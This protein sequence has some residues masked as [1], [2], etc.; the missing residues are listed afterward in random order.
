MTNSIIVETLRT[1]QPD[2]LR[3]FRKFIRSPFFN[4][5]PKLVLL[6]DCLR[7][8]YPEFSRKVLTKEKVFRKLHPGKIYS[9]EVMRKLISDLQFLAEEFLSY[10]EMESKYQF[11]KKIY[12]MHALRSRNLDKRFHKEFSELH[13]Q[14]SP[15]RNIGDDYFYRNLD[16]TKVELGHIIGRGKAG[17]YDIYNELKS[18]LNERSKY[19]IYYSLIHVYKSAQDLLALSH[20]YNFNF[21]E[22]LIYKFLQ[23]F[24]SKEFMEELSGADAS[25]YP[26][27]AIYYLNFMIYSGADKDDSNYF[28]L[29]ELILKHMKAFTVFERNNL[30]VFLENCCLEKIKEGKEQFRAEIHDI[31]NIILEGGLFVFRESDSMDT[32]RFMRII[33]NALML[34][35]YEWADQFIDKY[36]LTLSGEVR[37]DAV[38]YSMA[39]LH[40]A[41][42]DFSKA[43]EYTSKVKFTSFHLKFQTQ[44]VQLKSYYELG[45]MEEIL[46]Q[47]DS[48]RHTLQKDK[49]SPPDAKEKFFGFLLFMNKL[50]KLK[51]SL[52]TE[53]PD[54][55]EV[56]ETLK[57]N[58]KVY[59]KLWIEQKL[60][61]LKR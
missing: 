58:M 11:E 6:F 32:G 49:V 8:Y 23:N 10:T 4:E 25:L 36:K 50:V 37:D 51:L 2:E 46:Y 53:K 12:L 18:N 34:K 15:I 16:L 22:T 29:K 24:S 19:L 14:Y 40:F 5:S 56:L 27:I 35:K 52:K 61:E 38:G 21:H 31:Y 30:M 17:K 57:K 45:F 33:N 60:D 28:I 54:I 1:F 48:Y 59:E 47:L 42:S 7:K 26:V 39:V 41:K 9:D 44:I 55:D 43:I 20:R 3:S 13:K